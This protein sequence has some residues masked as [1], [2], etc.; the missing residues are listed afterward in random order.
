MPGGYSSFVFEMCIL[1]L[2]MVAHP[3]IPII[4]ALGRPTKIK[5]SGLAWTISGDAVLKKIN[6]RKK[7]Q[8]VYL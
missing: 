7:K 2:G 4:P 5:N 3:V 1:K 6:K 8:K